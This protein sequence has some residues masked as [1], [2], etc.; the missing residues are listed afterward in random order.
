LV[1]NKILYLTNEEY[2]YLEDLGLIQ[3]KGDRS[4]INNN[5]DNKFKLN[6]TRIK[7]VYRSVLYNYLKRLRN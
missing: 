7:E 2:I 1:K 6:N 5:I 3:L 4:D